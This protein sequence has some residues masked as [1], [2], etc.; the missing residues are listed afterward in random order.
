MQ[1]FHTQCASRQVGVDASTSGPDILPQPIQY[2]SDRRHFE[3][4]EL[5]IG[6]LAELVGSRDGGGRLHILTCK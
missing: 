1:A 4:L 2:R 5:G 6:R 3:D